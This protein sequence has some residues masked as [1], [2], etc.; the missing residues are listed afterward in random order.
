MICI[1][2][3]QAVKSMRYGKASFEVLGWITEE[4]EAGAS[5][6]SMLGLEPRPTYPAPPSELAIEA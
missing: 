2:S 6:S 4:D 3:N 1:E 5:R